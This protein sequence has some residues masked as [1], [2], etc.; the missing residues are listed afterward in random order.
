MGQSSMVQAPNQDHDL[1]VHRGLG[2][3][4]H[5]AWQGGGLAVEDIG[6]TRI[7]AVLFALREFFVVGFEADFNQCPLNSTV[8]SPTPPER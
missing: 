4:S 5:A 6:D 7:F 1:G 3:S 8:P 2:M